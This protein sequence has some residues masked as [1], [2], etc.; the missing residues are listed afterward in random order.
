M[1]YTDEQIENI[2]YEN[3][4]LRE[5][6]KGLRAPLNSISGYVM[7]LMKNAETPSKVLEYAHH[8]GLSCQNLL[9]MFDQTEELSSEF[10]P[11]KAEASNSEFALG[12]VIEAVSDATR[13]WM[14]NKHQE[15]Y[16]TTNGIGNDIFKGD[17]VL[18]TE[19]LRNLLSNAM[20]CTPEGG[21]VMLSV[22]GQAD[23]EPGY[24]NI[25]FSV[26]DGG[27]GMSAEALKRIF[28]KPG[29]VK[30]MESVPVGRIPIVQRFVQMMGGTIS[31][32]SAPGQGTTFTMGLRLQAVDHTELSFWED[33]GVQRILV[34]CEDLR[35]AARIRS[36]LGEI[37]L[38]T[39]CTSSGYGALQIIEQANIE[40]KEFDL[41]LLDRDIQDQPYTEF[42]EQL[43]GISFINTPTVVLMSDKPEHFTGEVHK[44]GIKRIM[45]K[46]FFYSTFKSI[47]DELSPGAKRGADGV[48][49]DNESPLLGLRIL[50]AENNTIHAN[51]IKELLEVEGA[52]C[53]LAGNGKAAV[54]MF[55]N[56]KPG[57]YN[58]IMLD[59]RMPVADGYSA[60]REIRGLDRSDA[61]TIPILAMAADPSEMDQE[62]ADTGGVTAHCMKPP[63]ILEIN[64]IMRTLR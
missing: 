37:G 46:P 1:K 48:P 18:I 50:L 10:R 12:Q 51:V 23:D 61:G 28:D 6:S 49:R 14:T 41:I 11:D 7:L 64:Q 59:I 52:R 15:L 22:V 21:E 55:R 43:C 4:R 57:Y 34:V 47:V 63:D 8:I 33:H 26:T 58:A 38:G 9:V 35:E 32:Q 2:I 25:Y 62:R 29:A 5:I 42:T 30:S 45:P 19:V 24:T 17:R 40:E 13:S 60:A 54:V 3:Q 56:S 20:H 16:V 27:D 44:S 53:E 36:M 39:V 31:A